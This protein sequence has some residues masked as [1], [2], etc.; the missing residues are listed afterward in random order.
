MKFAIAGRVIAVNSEI[1][2]S[3]CPTC[4][5]A[6]ARTRRLHRTSHPMP[7]GLIVSAA[8]FSFCTA[9]SGWPSA[10]RIKPLRSP[11]NRP[12]WR[13]TVTMARWSRTPLRNPRSAMCSASVRAA[14]TLPI[15]KLAVAN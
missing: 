13:A 14:R 9:F 7:T 6:S 10:I 5:R 3:A 8:Y 12:N 2:W 4:S 1:A 11:L 15:T